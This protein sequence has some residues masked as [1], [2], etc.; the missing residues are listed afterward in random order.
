M[1]TPPDHER[2]SRFLGYVLRHR[3]DAIGLSLD[4]EGWAEIDALLRLAQRE[5]PLT[6]AMIDD[7]VARNDKQ[8][9]AISDD[10]LRIRARQGHS[11]AVDL[12]LMPQVPPAK[13]YH[14][15]ATRFVD[16]IRREGLVKRDR[17][18]VHLSPSVDTATVV[19][20]RHGR[21]VVLTIDAAAMHA[22]GHVFFRSE[23]GVWLVD[24]VP[25]NF[26]AFPEST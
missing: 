18:H 21:V 15:T 16:A 19:G 14:G 5:L 6:R 1:H 10:G 23:N 20:A 3:P 22:A 7:A 4:A 9:Y 24:A 2:V 12:G 13:L 11:F 25:P 17:Q 8:R 26:L